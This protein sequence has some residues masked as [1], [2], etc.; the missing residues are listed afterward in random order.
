[1]KSITI[2][3]REGCTIVIND[4]MISRQHAV[5]RISSFGKM[6]VVDM[7][8]N[9]TFVNGV[10]LRPNTPF[11]V[12]RKDVINF[13]DV[14]QLDWSLIPNPAIY[15]KWGALALVALIAVV[16]VFKILSKHEPPKPDPV[17]IIE[18][19]VSPIEQPQAQPQIPT[20]P[21][22]PDSAKNGS[23]NERTTSKRPSIPSVD[24]FFKGRKDSTK[25][26]KDSTKA[27]K[28]STK[29]KKDNS[30]DKEKEEGETMPVGV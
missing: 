8:T 13:A 20:T 25:T 30:K 23:N 22:K 4:D 3:R 14:Y 9:G 2:G 15:Y 11:P 21:A 28:D 26:K 6:E 1:M 29:M 16:T 5:L 7:S 19:P 17:E 27:K 18:Q 10:K 12:T 24:D